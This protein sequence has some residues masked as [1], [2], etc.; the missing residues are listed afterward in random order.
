MSFNLSPESLGIVA[1]AIVSILFS[2]IPGLSSWFASLESTSKR[3]IMLA[4]MLVVTLA[5]VLLSCAGVVQGFAC[6]QTGFIQAVQVFVL[7]V[8]ANQAAYTITPRG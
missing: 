1:G 2:Y 8:M 3:L 6:N 4:L 5:A 7:A